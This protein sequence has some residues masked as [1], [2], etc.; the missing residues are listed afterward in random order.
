MDPDEMKGMRDEHNPQENEE[1]SFLNETVKNPPID[2]QKI[3]MKIIAITG[4]AILFGVIAALA[5]Y[6]VLSWRN[7][8]SPNPV[9]IPSDE[10]PVQT[11]VGSITGNGTQNGEPGGSGENAA[12]ASDTK[13]DKKN[14]GSTVPGG[15]SANGNDAGD[16]QLTG[17][18]ADPE[19]NIPD[20]QEAGT[21]GNNAA[22]AAPATPTP[23]PTEE[24]LDREALAT[25]SRVQSKLRGI[26]DKA[27]K[28]VVT[29]T[30]VT[31]DDEWFDITNVGSNAASGLIVA[32][33]SVSYLVLTDIDIIDSAEKIA[34]TLP[35]GSV[36]EASFQ[37]KDPVTGLCV[38]SIP[39][40][41]IA[42]QAR[43][44]LSVATLGNSYNVNTGDTVLAV[45]A[46]MG[47]AGTYACGG[48][49]S[50]MG[51]VEI[52]DGEYR[53]ITTDMYG[54]KSGSGV[55]INMDGE[56]VGII[57]QEYASDDHHSIT[58]IPI[59][60]LKSLI[61]KLSN[62][63]ALSYIGIH[64][65]DISEKAA[66]AQD[67]PSG[68]YVSSVDEDSPALQA[69][70]Q[71]GD[72]ITSVGLGSAVTLRSLHENIMNRS[73]GDNVEVTVMRQGSSK[74]AEFDFVITIGELPEVTESESA[75]SEEREAEDASKSDESGETESSAA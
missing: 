72:I 74:Y 28:S 60:P 49:V 25:Y 2:F 63:S 10:H 5:F 53:L 68:V 13:G 34:V 32:D 21:E 33:N 22:S 67:I 36:V 58:A 9:T 3:F 71:P 11:V 52:V 41:K 42:R 57:E 17:N 4:A 35:D 20:S 65:L 31:A 61:E 29:V 8:T 38:I 6:V 19:A 23:T 70:L 27:M 50:L 64:G 56:V 7:S 43:N 59:S 54:G 15:N 44:S 12:G 48:V 66:E 40:D 46:P 51:S 24:E 55:L 1:Y 30:G 62:N 14:A 26:A 18:G 69:G 47:A 39:R 45:G 75:A 37:K 73:P 16:G